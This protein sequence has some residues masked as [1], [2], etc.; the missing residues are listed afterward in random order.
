MVSKKA[1]RFVMCSYISKGSWCETLFVLYFLLLGFALYLSDYCISSHDLYP[2]LVDKCRIF[3]LNLDSCQDRLLYIQRLMKFRKVKFERI[4]AIPGSE[5]N[6]YDL[7]TRKRLTLEEVSKDSLVIDKTLYIVHPDFLQ[8]PIIFNYDFRKSFQWHYPYKMSIGELGCYYSHRI[9]WQKIVDEDLP[10]AVIFEDDVMLY[11]NFHYKLLKILEAMPL[12]TDWVSLDQKVSSMN[13]SSAKSPLKLCAIQSKRITCTGMYAYIITNQGAK[14]LL[15]ITR[16]ASAP[17]DIEVV[18]S[19]L[20]KKINQYMVSIR[21]LRHNYHLESVLTSMG[22]R[23]WD[24]E[25]RVRLKSRNPNAVSKPSG[26]VQW[27]RKMLLKRQ[28]RA[29]VLQREKAKAFN[30]KWFMRESNS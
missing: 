26:I 13:S 27:R 29:R 19:H 2:S 11:S 5:L 16:N 14:K 4:R 21:V 6:F 8:Y 1:E 30:K 7:K 10:Y 3:V 9:I 24:E 22:R 25:K 17:I 23:G 18:M 15:E 12:D 20:S 28:I